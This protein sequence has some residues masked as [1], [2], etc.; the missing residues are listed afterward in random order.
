[1]DELDFSRKALL[2]A[3]GAAFFDCVESVGGLALA[4][5]GARKPGEITAQFRKQWAGRLP[6]P[7]NHDLVRGI[8][9]AQLASTDRIARRHAALLDDLP[10]TELAPGERDFARWLRGWLD[11]RLRRLVKDIDFGALTEDDIQRVLDDMVHPS[12]I[13]GYAGHAALSRA[14]AEDA[15]LAE[16]QAAG[17]AAVPARFAALFRA[18]TDAAEGGGWYDVFALFISEEI[19]TN[20]RFRAILFAA[21]FVDLKRLGSAAEGRIVAAQAGAVE[22]LNFR[23]DDF[24][25][26]LRTATAGITAIR[27]EQA[28][29]EVVDAT[30]HA[31]TMAAHAATLQAL[32]QLKDIP[33][34]P[35]RAGLRRLLGEGLADEAIP[36]AL[37]RFADEYAK[38]RADLDRRTITTTEIE[39]LRAAARF[40]LKEGDL[41]LAAAKLEEAEAL[42]VEPHERLATERATLLGERAAVASLR[43]ERAEAVQL[44]RQAAAVVAFDPEQAFHHTLDEAAVLSSW[45][46]THGDSA[47]LRE[48]VTAYDRAL[49][50]AKPG[51]DAELSAAVGANLC[52]TL[53]ILGERGDDA[54]L[55]RSIETGRAALKTVTSE[56]SPS[57]WA[58]TQTNLGL[59]LRVLGER[60][61]WVA[62]EQSVYA[63]RAALAAFTHARSPMG[64]ALANHNLAGA[65]LVVG[66]SRD[67]AALSD[68]ATAIENA[69]QVITKQN[70]PGLW[71]TIQTNLGNLCWTIG[72]RSD[73]AMLHGAVSAFRGALEV[74]ERDRTPHACAGTQNNLG[75]V[76]FTLGE[77]GDGA[78]L[79]EAEAAFRAA[80]EI[81]SR[82]HTPDDWAMTIHNLGNVQVML[83]QRGNTEALHKGVHLYRLALEVRTQKRAPAKWALTMRNLGGALGLT[84]KRGDEAALHEAIEVYREVLMVFTNESAPMD[85]AHTLENLARAEETLGELG[86]R[87]SRFGSALE[88]TELALDEYRRQNAPYD[89]GTATRL[90]D[91]LRARLGLAAAP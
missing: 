30:R 82:E 71:A 61:D 12:A 10:P 34:P 77:R 21:E 57:L 22:A 1:V 60:G 84:G 45:G 89:V 67:P 66:R 58:A 68:A 81:Y 14:A 25:T 13:E 55:I 64:W 52:N 24:E 2:G 4:A 70:L 26:W 15:A 41:P 37:E 63:L 80:L 3:T 43:G 76:L 5:I 27:G 51:S 62:L 59:A 54:A 90:R 11:E 65:L 72:S 39:M 74:L 23:L 40:A 50:L 46:E 32:A 86:G 6:L 48:A 29:R 7:E 47:H 16:L 87:A 33:L 18:Q 42:L 8:R 49:S 17:A 9:T 56:N 36:G 31:E 69:L 35:L 78:A 79:G 91:R 38:L 73:G 85:W 19:K 28:R 83:G 20:E 44:Y 53:R 88:H 75:L